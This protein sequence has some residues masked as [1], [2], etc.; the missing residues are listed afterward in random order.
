MAVTH[1]ALQ[2][3]TKV[4]SKLAYRRQALLVCLNH[5]ELIKLSSNT[6]PIPP[7]AQLSWAMFWFC[8]W[9]LLQSK[10]KTIY[11]V[12]STETK[13]IQSVTWTEGIK[14]KNANHGVFRVNHFSIYC[15]W[16]ARILKWKLFSPL[17]MRIPLLGLASKYMKWKKKPSSVPI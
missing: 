15:I 5:P 8:Q 6:S 1:R 9:Q 17:K 14:T 3:F 10:F 13:W 2:M 4:N 7:P 12:A 16:Y 11:L